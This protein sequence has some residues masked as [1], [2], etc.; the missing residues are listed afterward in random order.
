MATATQLLAQQIEGLRRQLNAV[1]RTPQ[2]PHSSV[3]NGAITVVSNGQPTAYVGV[4]YDGTSGAVVVAGPTPPTPSVPTLSQVIGGV[5]VQWGGTFVDPQPGFSSPVVAPMDFAGVDVQ[6]SADVNFGDT[7]FGPTHGTITSAQGGEIFVAWH[8]PNTPLY[9]RLITRSKAGKF[10]APSLVAGPVNSGQVQIGDIGFPIAQYSGGNTVYYTVSPATPVAPSWGFTAGDLWLE[11]IGTATGL[12]GGAP[13][14]TPLYQTSRWGGSTWVLLQ[15]QGISNSLASA[16]AA[17]NTADGKATLFTGSAT[18]SYSGA[19]GTAYWISGTDNVPQVW[20]GTT[21]VSYQLGNGAIQP[22]SLIA[23]NVIATGTVT[24]ALLESTMVLA[25]TIVAG[26]LAGD[27]AAL[28]SDGLHIFS[29]ITGE[30]VQE[31]ARFATG[32]G[33]FFGVVD[34]TGAQVA[35]IDDTGAISGSSVTTDQLVV[36]GENFTDWIGGLSDGVVGRVSLYSASNIGPIHNPYGLV[37]VGCALQAGRAYLISYLYTF[38]VT[39]AGAEVRTR[40][41][42]TSGV[43]GDTVT[44]P[45]TPQAATAIQDASWYFTPPY[46]GTYYTNANSFIYVPSITS[47]FRFLLTTERG[48]G[49]TG[50]D[51]E[52]VINSSAVVPIQLTVAD[53]GPAG[54]VSGGY[55]A[56]GGTYYSGGGGGSPTSVTQKYDTG[57]IAPAGHWT[58]RGNGTLRTDTSDVVQGWDPSGYN[59]DGKGGWNFNIP[60]ISGTVNRVDLYLYNNWSYYNSGGQALISLVSNANTPSPAT[61]QGAWNPGR[62]YPKPGGVT[63]TLPS[64]WYSSFKGKTSIGLYLGPSGGS[65][66][67]YYIRSAGPS[68]RLRIWYT[69]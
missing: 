19:A 29:T 63:V 25:N 53:I 67:T 52:T 39:A 57:N 21:W 49:A 38:T 24:A 1:Q 27:H 4:Q 6:V 13:S 43:D 45:P 59:G 7:G 17:Q 5:R 9:A 26:D 48:A 10:S 28:E 51:T 12:A 15:D 2:L 16:I 35:G 61:L 68:A 69:Q 66:E 14:G 8:A 47:R 18:P 44:E 60:N 40:I 62:N 11:Q 36:A 56:G 55:Q 54:P 22:N 23:S 46:A 32:S 42:E 58:Y 41:V 30:G 33:N 34:S 20:N 37:E 64:S 50:S 3:D 65:N 31:V